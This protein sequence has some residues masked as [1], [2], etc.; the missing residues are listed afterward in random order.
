[1]PLLKSSEGSNSNKFLRLRQKLISRVT[2]FGNRYDGYTA[3]LQVENPLKREALER[4]I[5]DQKK[6]IHIL[7]RYIITPPPPNQTPAKYIKILRK[8]MSWP[9]KRQHVSKI[10]GI[11][12]AQPSMR[13][14]HPAAKIVI[15]NLHAG[16]LTEQQSTKRFMLSRAILEAEKDKKAVIFSTLTVNAENIDRV[17][18]KGSKDF[19]TYIHRIRKQQIKHGAT[20]DKPVQYLAVTEKGGV[21]GRLHIHAILIVENL[22]GIGDINRQGG[23][24]IN[25]AIHHLNQYWPHGMSYNIPMRFDEFDAFG[26]AGWR[27]PCDKLTHQPKPNQSIEQITAYMIKYVLKSQLNIGDQQWRTK[28]TQQLGTSQITQYLKTYSNRTIVQILALPSWPDSVKLSGIRMPNS[29]LRRLLVTILC[30]RINHPELILSLTKNPS[31]IFQQLG[32]CTIQKKHKSSSQNVGNI[33]TQL[34]QPTG[35]SKNPRAFLVLKQAME[36]RFEEKSHQTPIG[37]GNIT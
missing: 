8:T 16:N 29:L 30:N 23:Y 20:S 33:L 9:P 31:T 19:Q 32:Q 37:C 21:T 25:D 26:S 18:A 1:M 15:E 24:P 11:P 17:F 14:Q 34:M 22:M 2:Y 5:N 13:R 27:W 12:D 28:I 6:C 10:L 7:D 35:I 4:F 3:S 36:K